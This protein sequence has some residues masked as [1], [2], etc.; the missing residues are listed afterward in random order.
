[1]SVIV[2]WQVFGVV[3]LSQ[4]GPSARYYSFERRFRDWPIEPLQPQLSSC[5][6]RTLE[7][8]PAASLDYSTSGHSFPILWELPRTT[9]K[10]NANRL[11]PEQAWRHHLLDPSTTL[12]VLSPS[13]SVASFV[14]VIASQPPAPRHSDPIFHSAGKP[15]RSHRHPLN[16]TTESSNC[17]PWKQDKPERAKTSH[18]QEHRNSILPRYQPFCLSAET[19]PPTAG[20]T[21]QRAETQ[22]RSRNRVGVEARRGTV[23]ARGKLSW[24]EAKKEEE[25]RDLTSAKHN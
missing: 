21:S 23:S 10:P 22:A 7:P 1:M 4:R 6:A 11:K 24:V 19:V 8:A 25:G 13:R 3:G 17:P 14:I 16:Q 2:V 20:I 5:A 15:Q 12:T 9:H 18:E